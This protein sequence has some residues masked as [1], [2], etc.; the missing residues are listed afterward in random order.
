MANMLFAAL[1]LVSSFGK[2]SAPSDI[3][4]LEIQ[5]NNEYILSGTYSNI[6]NMSG[7]SVTNTNTEDYFYNFEVA[8]YTKVVK[9]GNE[10]SFDSVKEGDRLRV[11]YDG[12][13]S[14]VFPPKLDNVTRIEVIEDNEQK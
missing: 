3:K 8:P 5:K 1:S 11:T 7:I 9:N 13:I 6:N 4:S 12:S 10:V 2:D 14:L